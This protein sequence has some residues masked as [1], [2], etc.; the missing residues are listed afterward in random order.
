VF[1]L[2]LAYHLEKTDLMQ[3][4][5][6]NTCK[7]RDILTHENLLFMLALLDT[8]VAIL[9]LVPQQKRMRSNLKRV[10]IR[11]CGLFL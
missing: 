4:T 3:S 7:T 8:G 1:K 10:L 5:L 11:T 6:S 2:E 9:S